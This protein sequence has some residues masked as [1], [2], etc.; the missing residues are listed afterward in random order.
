MEINGKKTS[1][2]ILEAVIKQTGVY[3]QSRKSR[4]SVFWGDQ[5]FIP[6]VSVDYVP[7]HHVDILCKLGPMMDAKEW[8]E[9]GMHKYGLIAVNKDGNAAQVEKVSHPE[10]VK[11]LSTFGDLHSVGVSL[12][13]FSMSSDFTLGLLK[14]F[15]SELSRKEGKLDT[16]PHF[17]MPLTLS[18]ESYISIQGAKRVSADVATKQYE[19]MADFIKPFLTAKGMGVFGAVDVGTTC[20]WWDYG[21]LQLY[22][23]NNM[24]M[25]GDSHEAA[26]IRR[27]FQLSHKQVDSVIRAKVCDSS[28]VISSKIGGNSPEGLLDVEMS[29][30][31]RVHVPDLHVSNSLLVN[32]SAKRVIGKNVILYNVADDSPDGLILD[33][34]AVLAHIYLPG[35]KQIKLESHINIDGGKEWSNK[36]LKNSS[37]FEDI[38]AMNMDIE[39][40]K[41]LESLAENHERVI[42]DLDF[43]M[44]I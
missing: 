44:M 28:C 11:L 27:F 20:Y 16:D 33:D 3:A 4:V 21:Q 29:V 31:S 1:M 35:G 30:I 6:S 24:M 41:S 18:L 13:S 7:K 25:N 42:K 22:K 26:S 32:V 2:T 5:V 23:K 10:A 34:G 14:N 36:V 17:W 15:E 39:L 19:R 43:G 9:K 40:S 12:G 38:H 8:E 37:S